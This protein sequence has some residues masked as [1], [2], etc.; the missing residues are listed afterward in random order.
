MMDGVSAAASIV[1]LIQAAAAIYDYGCV[2]Y[3]A[4]AEQR[5]LSSAIE[6]LKVKLISLKQQD[7]RAIANP[8]DPWYQ[9]VR[10]ILASAKQFGDDGKVEPDLS[11]KGP[12]VL[13]RL[14]FAMQRREDKLSRR[15]IG[16]T[17]R[18]RRLLWYWERKRFE[19]MIAEIEQ[20]TQIV[21]TVCNYDGFT[22]G[23]DTN[24]HVKLGNDRVQNLGNDMRI[25][26]DGLGKAA[27]EKERKA[28]DKRRVA[29]LSWLSPLRFRERQSALLNQ[30]S[31]SVSMSRLLT[32]EEY[33]LWEGGQQYMLHCEGKPGAGKVRSFSP[34]SFHNSVGLLCADFTL[35]CRYP[36]SARSL[37]R[38]GYAS[39]LHVSQL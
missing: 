6:G 26:K 13:R 10:A 19:E 33:M 14:E 7:E 18:P 23:L 31:T 2:T 27:K 25:I 21:D 35:C 28:V 15:Q 1:S 8:E 37:H 16:C 34:K 32:S 12:G 36:A 22:L 5:K 3:N 30:M 29:I 38:P 17:A 4:K 11:E 20:W 9:G 39:P 24:A